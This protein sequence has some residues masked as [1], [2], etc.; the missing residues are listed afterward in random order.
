M[1]NNGLSW[2]LVIKSSCDHKINIQCSKCSTN[3]SHN[4]INKVYL[5]LIY[6]QHPTRTIHSTYCHF[7]FRL[8]LKIIGFILVFFYDYLL[9][10]WL[11]SFLGIN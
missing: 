11:K 6:S 7:K 8:T 2:F 9:S 3:N 1:L 10:L 5:F 4:T